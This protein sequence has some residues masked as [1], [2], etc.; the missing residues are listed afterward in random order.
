MNKRIANIG[1]E[2]I[3]RLLDPVWEIPA[4]ILLAVAFA[5]TEGLRW[6]FLGLLLF[7]DAVVP[8]IFFLTMLKNKQIKNWDMQRREERVPLY[9]FTLVCHLAG[10]W[11]A[12]ELG[13]V[14]LVAVLLVFYVTGIVFALITMRWKISLHAGVNA[15][16]FTAINMFYDWQYSWL[17]GLLALV[18]W[19]RVYQRH[20]TC[21]QVIVGAI[22]GG[23]MVLVGLSL[24][25]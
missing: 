12:H 6:R 7:I 10:L 13:K 19:A 22:L 14:E 8:M 16:L 1:A 25:L 5:A 4:A 9:A 2:I 20:H 3:S 23:G 17:Y 21:E 24:V 15:V 11:L 18:M